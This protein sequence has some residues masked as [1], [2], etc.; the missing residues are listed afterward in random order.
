MAISKFQLLKA[1][2]ILTFIF[3]FL[4]EGIMADFIGPRIIIDGKIGEAVNE[5]CVEYDD[6]GPSV[7]SIRTVNAKGNIFLVDK[8]GISIFNQKG[9]LLNIVKPKDIKN[10]EG[11]PAFLDADSQSNIYTS[12][13][14]TKLQKYNLK[15]E[16]IWERE[17]VIG[18]I[19]IQHD[20]N[21]MLWGFRP[22][23]KDK[24]RNL[25]YASSGQFL[26]SYD[27]RPLELGLVQENSV[28][29]SNY[30]TTIE[31][32]DKKWKVKGHCARYTRDACGVLY[33][34]DNAIVIRFDDEG[35]DVAFIGM[36]DEKTEETHAPNLPPGVDTPINV[37]EQ[38]GAP[39]LAPNG[40]V[41]TWKRT[42]DKYSIIKW[43]WVD[44]PEC[45]QNLEVKPTANSLKFTWQ[46]PTKDADNITYYQLLQSFNICGPFRQTALIKKD[47]LNYEDRDVKKG[48]TYYYVV[49]AVRGKEYSGN[50]NK[51]CGQIE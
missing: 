39:V 42:P 47:Q 5:F 10:T 2:I 50:S 18:R 13:Y 6:M 51:V 23:Q 28:G 25:L 27:T 11:W 7:P 46:K 17:I 15:G 35:K 21:I 32:P 20:D 8:K 41:Y 30:E 26:K 44:G 49:K 34:V 16:K 24:E 4:N 14:D 12:N 22:D 45:P 29:G 1:S 31:F 40:D 48:E 43:V 9:N 33:C 38:Y 36:P 3:L 19:Q 37:L